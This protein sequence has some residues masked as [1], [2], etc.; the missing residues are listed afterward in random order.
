[1]F[2]DKTV[3][4]RASLQVLRDNVHILKSFVDFLV[5]KNTICAA[6]IISQIRDFFRLTNYMGCGKPQ[7]YFVIE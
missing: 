7:L 3:Y 4:F 2:S 6:E 1:M 5:F